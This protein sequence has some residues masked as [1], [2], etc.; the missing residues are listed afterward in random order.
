[1]RILGLDISSTCTGVSVVN[2]GYL[3]INT[4]DTIVPSDKFSLGQK[5]VFFEKHIKKLLKKYNPDIVVIED[6]F[7]GPNAKTFKT[8]AMFRGIIFKVVF[9]KM[10]IDP[11]SIMPTEARKLVGAKGVK[12][13]DGFQFVINKY[14][15]KEFVFEK[16]NDITDAVVL[17]LAYY[18][19]YKQSLLIPP[20][21]RSRKKRSK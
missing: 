11:K 19:Q 1:M 15:L 6:I 10:K 5:L 21:P 16:H 2:D 9:E 13:E 12:K 17:A 18:E 20:Q 4:L 3:D 14:G 8:L 7:K